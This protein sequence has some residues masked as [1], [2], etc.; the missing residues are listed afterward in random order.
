M[1]SAFL[2]LNAV[3]GPPGDLW[4]SITPCG[5][6][7]FNTIVLYHVS[8]QD[9]VWVKVLEYEGFQSP[10]LVT[11]AAGT[12]WLFRE[13]LVY[14]IVDNVPELMAHMDARLVVVDSAGRVW[15]VS[16]HEGQ[17]WLWT[18]DPDAE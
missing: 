18:I 7:C 5:G 9:D 13:S 3:P 4:V 14:R 11:D 15:F 1:S 8:T 12:P 17:G 10:S 2:I 6:S 16:K